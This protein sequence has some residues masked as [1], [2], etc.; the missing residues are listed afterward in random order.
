MKHHN[1]LFYLQEA[2]NEQAGCSKCEFRIESF[3]K[4]YQWK[5]GFKGITRFDKDG[6]CLSL[7]LKDGDK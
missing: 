2:Y 7:K 6:K 1:K 4:Q 3:S 5:C